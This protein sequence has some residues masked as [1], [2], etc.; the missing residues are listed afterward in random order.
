MPSPEGSAEEPVEVK[1]GVVEVRDLVRDLS[2]WNTLYLAG[3]M[4]KP[5]RA[6]SRA[7]MRP[8][9][10]AHAPV[11]WE[12]VLELQPDHQVQEA[13]QQNLRAAMAAALLMLGPRFSPTDLYVA[14]ARALGP[15]C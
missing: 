9:P 11:G 5:V 1:Y 13:Q 7:Y 4:H 15:H 8:V 2:Q 6:R 12:Q 10:L 14:R 3:R